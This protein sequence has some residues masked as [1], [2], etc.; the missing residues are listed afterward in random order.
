MF[1]KNWLYLVP[2]YACTVAET[3]SWLWQL[4]IVSDKV[5]IDHWIFHQKPESWT[6]YTIFSFTCGFFISIA[7]LAGHEL[8]HNREPINKF[9]GTWIYTKFFYTHFL[10]E[11]TQGHHRTMATEEDPAT[12]RKGETLWTFVFT[13]HF[14]GLT[15]TWRRECERTK[16][17]YGHDVG[18]VR[19][20]LEGKI[21]IGF[22][23]HAVMLAIIYHFLGWASLM[24]Q[25]V[26]T[27]FGLW[28]VGV[29]NFVEHYGL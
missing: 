7:S 22:I 28:Y 29:V 17:L 14:Y 3:L 23:V 26:Y 16:R 18:F 20:V 1:R 25:F 19:N 24:Y 13:S 10:D 9:W 8:M 2:V 5:K 27:F 12:S 15:S 4:I 11:H 21:I 6:E